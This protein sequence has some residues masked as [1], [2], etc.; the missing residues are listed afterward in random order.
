M[1]ANQA[2]Y[3]VRVMCRLLK[4]SASGFYAWDDRPL[5][6]RARE[7]GDLTARIQAIHRL[8]RRA[9]RVGGVSREDRD[10][11]PAY[12]QRLERYRTAVQFVST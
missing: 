2:S 11:H 6:A 3:P 8:L 10:R 12:V 7:D 5:S 1:K 4:V 9:R